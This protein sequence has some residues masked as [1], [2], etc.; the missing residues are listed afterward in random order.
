VLHVERC[1]E[2]VLKGFA[3][4]ALAWSE[5]LRALEHEPIRSVFQAF[6]YRLFQ[7]RLCH[8]YKRLYFGKGYVY[9]VVHFASL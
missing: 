3:E 9:W 6:D 2:L 4:L 1:L 5:V 7:L 8:G